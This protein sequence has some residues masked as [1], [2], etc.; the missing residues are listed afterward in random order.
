M[1]RF[2]SFLSFYHW[3]KKQRLASFFEEDAT[4]VSRREELT[5]LLKKLEK[6]NQKMAN[7]QVVRRSELDTS[8]RESVHEVSNSS[9][10]L[11]QPTYHL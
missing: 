1:F 11:F 5:H 4:I 3:V 9:L 8:I 2:L 7:I 6:A 10:M